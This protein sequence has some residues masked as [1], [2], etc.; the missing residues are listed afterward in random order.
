L[1]VQ[2]GFTPKAAR[3]V[4]KF[5]FEGGNEMIDVRIRAYH[6]PAIGNATHK[7]LK[8]KPIFHGFLPVREW[9]QVHRPDVVFAIYNNHG[10][11]ILLDKMP[12]FVVGAAIRQHPSFGVKTYS[13]KPL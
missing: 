1:H 8:G 9:R 12:T 11:D 10:L 6:I 3:W 4:T 7:S 13:L 5:A 2:F